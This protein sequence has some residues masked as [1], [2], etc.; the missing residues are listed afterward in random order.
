MFHIPS[1][2]FDNW[3]TEENPVKT[4]KS[5]SSLLENTPKSGHRSNLSPAFNLIS[6]ERVL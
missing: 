3:L 6:K 1:I 4:T 5:F 2:G